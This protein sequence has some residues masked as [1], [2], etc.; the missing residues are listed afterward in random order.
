MTTEL[1]NEFHKVIEEL[2]KERCNLVD[3]INT[4]E[5]EG[6]ETDKKCITEID[7]VISSILVCLSF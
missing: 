2:L 5:Y 1:R 7:K 6:I 3:K 4:K